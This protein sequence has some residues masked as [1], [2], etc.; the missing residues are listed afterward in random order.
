MA[1]RLPPKDS[2]KWDLVRK[3]GIPVPVFKVVLRV[4]AKLYVKRY[5]VKHPIILEGQGF[6]WERGAKMQE[7]VVTEE[8]RVNW[9]AAMFA[10]P[11]VMKCPNCGCYLWNEGKKVRCPDC[12]HEWYTNQERTT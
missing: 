3:N 11:G 2:R 1:R 6:D 9:A 5:K 10:D 7:R 4:L 8:G 12:G